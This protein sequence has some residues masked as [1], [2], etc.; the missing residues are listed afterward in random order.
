[1]RKR[2]ARRKGRVRDLRE[3]DFSQINSFTSL[4][5]FWYNFLC[6][7][8]SGVSG[9]A[10]TITWNSHFLLDSFFFGVS[11]DYYVC[12]TQNN[13]GGQGIDGVFLYGEFL[14]KGLERL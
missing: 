3:C 1:M 7:Y 14:V 6:F 4:T 11:G 12:T 9:D 2:R 8:P 5:S 13:L 10:P